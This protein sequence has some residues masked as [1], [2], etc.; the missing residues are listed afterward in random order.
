[1]AVSYETSVLGEGNHASLEIPDAILDQLG[2]NRRAPLKVTINGHTYQSTATGVDGQCRVVFPSKERLAAGANS[3]DKVTV[4]L[5]LDPGIRQVEIPA[6]L[7]QALED[8]SLIIRFEA[9]NYS[10]RK[11]FA[12]SVAEAKAPETKERRIAKVL[13]TLQAR[14]E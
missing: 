11:E 9:C 6:E 3:G 14:A 7:K 5:E 8:S 1:M 2:A 4:T 13:E 12:R 10:T